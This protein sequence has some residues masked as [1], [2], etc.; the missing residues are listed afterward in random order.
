M[1]APPVA[2]FVCL[3]LYLRFGRDREFLERIYPAL[4]RWYDW[5]L[6]PGESGKPRSDGNGDGLLEWRDGMNSGLDNNPRWD[7][8]ERDKL[9]GQMKLNAICLNSL[10]C[11]DAWCLGEMAGDLERGDDVSRF[12]REY[13]VL[14]DLINERLWSEERGLYLD[15]GWDGRLSER[16]SGANFWV[17]ASGIVPQERVSRILGNLLDE[18]QFWGEFVI[19]SISFDDPEYGGV[20]W[21]GPIWSLMNYLVYQGLKRYECDEVSGRFAEKSV[22]LLMRDWKGRGECHENYDARTGEGYNQR[23]QSWGPLFTMVGLEELAD[24]EPWSG[25]RFGS[26]GLSSDAWVRNMSLSGHSY[27]VSA[28]PS[29]TV[30]SRDGREIYRSDRP[31]VVRGYELTKRGARFRVKCPDRTKITVNE[32]K[33]RLERILDAGEH[34]IDM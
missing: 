3:R 19:P 11:L 25:L 7:G 26:V 29:G 13:K 20:Y 32:K 5:W 6:L 14:G 8:V 16:R 15:Q 27:D 2:S 24:M 23:F 28:G 33:G 9:T 17:L 4:V 10:R 1:T 18:R 12:K 22:D 21:R 31:T 34:S 30:V